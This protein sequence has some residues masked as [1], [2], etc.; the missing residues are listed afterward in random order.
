MKTTTFK[1]EGMNCD[2][3]ANTIKTLVESEPGV[4]MATVSFEEGQ[5]RI[6]YDPQ[7]TGED[8]LVAVIQKPGFRV[9]GRD[10]SNSAHERGFNQRTRRRGQTLGR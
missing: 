3:C 7:S 6:L 1:I 9:A 2:G 5:A 10:C 8:R 4:Q